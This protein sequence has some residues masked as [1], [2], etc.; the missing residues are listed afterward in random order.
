MRSKKLKRKIYS[1]NK[2][3]DTAHSVLALLSFRKKE[4]K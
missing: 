1:D 3:K 4:R 2:T